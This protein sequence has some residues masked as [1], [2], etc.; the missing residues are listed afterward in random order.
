[1]LCPVKYVVDSAAMWSAVS[2]K[3]NSYIVDHVLLVDAARKRGIEEARRFWEARFP[4]EPYDITSSLKTAPL[5]EDAEES[6]EVKAA[7]RISY[8][9][10]AAAERQMA[11]HYQVAITPQYQDSKWL[12]MAVTRYVSMFLELQRRRAKSVW[13]P[14]YDIDV[15][16]HTHMLHP[17]MYVKDTT[18]RTGRLLPHDDTLNDRKAG[19]NLMNRWEDTVETWSR[20]FGTS[21]ARPGGM[22]RGNITPEERLSVP[23]VKKSVQ[24]FTEQISTQQLSSLSV[25]DLETVLKDSDKTVL[26]HIPWVHTTDSRQA[27][28][29]IQKSNILSASAATVFESFA[30]F[31]TEKSA[32]IA[33]GRFFYTPVM[34]DEMVESFSPF[35]ELYHVN[36]GMPSLSYPMASAYLAKAGSI[37]FGNSHDKYSY[38]S[39]PGG[40]VFVLRIAGEDFGLLAAGWRGFQ[41]PVDSTSDMVTNKKGKKQE[42]HSFQHCKPE[43]GHLCLRLWLLGSGSPDRWYSLE[44]RSQPGTP[45]QFEMKLPM[46]SASEALRKTPAKLGAIGFDLSDGK[47]EFE[48]PEHGV[49]ACLIAMAASMLHVILQPRMEP[50]EN[51]FKTS[52]YPSWSSPQKEHALLRA[53]GGEHFHESSRRGF[54]E[55]LLRLPM[56]NQLRKNMFFA[57]A[58]TLYPVREKR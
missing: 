42:Q 33:R 27:M 13:V 51:D 22:W 54:V 12:Q 40:L 28:E 21:V 44:N 50:A 46:P 55:V 45:G 10:V 30:S 14:T 15:V 58:E 3:E 35:L 4:Q 2:P 29:T 31:K 11:F 32:E 7:S 16:W 52:M 9:I 8:D 19:S 34:V 26:D 25:C 38:A 41:E 47:I 36:S 56:S 5:Q 1:M 6:V 17:R 37:C 23:V 20:E 24:L 18:I 39:E 43:P 53:A 49:P 48:L 57:K